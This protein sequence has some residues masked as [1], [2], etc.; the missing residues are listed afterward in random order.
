MKAL[1]LSGVTILMVSISSTGCLVSGGGSQDSSLKSQINAPVTPTP[2]TPPAT[3][4]PV[5]APTVA[6]NQGSVAAVDPLLSVSIVKPGMEQMRISLNDTCT[7]G[8]WENYSDARS[9]EIDP[10]Q[11]NTRVN[12]SVMFLNNEFLP[13]PCYQTSILHDNIAPVIHVDT[14]VPALTNNPAQRIPF[15]A[16]DSGSGVGELFCILPGQQSATPCAGAFTGNLADGGYV[17]QFIASDVA[18]NLSQPTS[19]SF[20]VDSTAPVLTLNSV[21][22]QISSSTSGRFEFAATDNLTG[23]KAFECKIDSQAFAPC[24]SGVTFINLSQGRH[25]F[26]ARA[27]DNAG[28]VSAHVTYNWTVDSTAPTVRFTQ[29]PPAITN[30]TAATFAFTGVESDGTALTRFECRLNGG[31]FSSCASPLAIGSVIEGR[32][33][34]SLRGT[35][36]AGVSSSEVT[37]SWTV[38]LT[39]PQVTI[40]KA[41][42]ALTNLVDAS[43][44]FQTS[45]ALSGL[46]SVGCSLDGGVLTDCSSLVA[47]Y[48]SLAGNRSHTFRVFVTDQAGNSASSNLFAWYIDTTLPSVQITSGP[49]SMTAQTTAN[50]QVSGSDDHS[51]VTFKCRLDNEPVFSSCDSTITY[52]SINQGSHTL[53][54]VSVDGAGNTSLPQ[55][56]VW[57]VVT[58]GP[59]IMFTQVPSATIFT[60]DSPI[61]AYTVSDSLS[62]V[63]TTKCSLDGLNIACGLYGDTLTFPQQTVGTHTFT[64]VSTNLAGISSTR[65]YS[66]A[67]QPACSTSLSTTTVPTKMLFVIDMSGSNESAPG[68]ALGPSCT[69][70]AK[71]MRAGSIQTFLNEY[72][73]R[74][75]FAWAF[76]IFKGTT[77]TA[78]IN[79]GLP[80]S[81]IFSHAN[82]MQTAITNFKGLPDSDLTPYMAA[83]KLATTVISNDPD[84]KSPLNPQY[85]VVFMSDGQPNGTGD[86]PSNILAQIK[87]ITDLSP[88]RVSFNAVYYGPSNKTASDLIQQMATNGKGNF[89]NTNTNPTGLSFSISDLVSV[90]VTT[91]K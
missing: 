52:P 19:V 4:P 66:F 43:F 46:A 13:T 15:H 80:T 6:I 48:S 3:P 69:D 26:T 24:D 30:T 37:Y 79:N 2:S 41:P 23:V 58:T 76:N 63:A 62:Q 73:S 84:L 32:N 35:S 50:F 28:N 27:I 89:L 61:L 25:A 91:C 88:G 40:T 39:A 81:P 64:I 10:S 59:A 85:I 56:Y 7:G 17:V 49:A 20:T 29:T 53:T 33:S 90:P 1:L 83:L 14:A 34:L 71:K 36:R 82:A 86:T 22:S 72:G 18:G 31:A 47:N 12:I 75:N 65:S 68:C 78:L 8:T 70:E 5:Q 44:T 77:S 60:T 57:T 87:T 21:P 74:G 16:E 9:I 54:V 38:D 45:D 55:N 11:Y 51:A 67:V 42:N